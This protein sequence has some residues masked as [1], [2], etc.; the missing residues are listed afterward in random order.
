MISMLM[1]VMDKVDHM[2]E[3][4]GD[5]SRDVNGNSKNNKKLMLE[6]SI[7]VTEMRNAFDGLTGRLDIVEESV[8][9][10]I[11]HWKLTQ[12]NCKEEK[13]IKKNRAECSI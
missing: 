9:L 13:R 2:Q 1:T 12:L 3:Q 4:K 10:K 5:V 8:D 7:T 6:I 11:Y